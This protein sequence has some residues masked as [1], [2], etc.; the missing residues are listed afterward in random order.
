MNYTYPPEEYR[1]LLDAYMELEKLAFSPSDSRETVLN[2]LAA[3]TAQ[4]CRIADKASAMVRE[5][6]E[7]FLKAPET[8][9]AVDVEA[10]EAL[11]AVLVP[12]DRAVGLDMAIAYLVSK[13]L[14]DHYRNAG[15]DLRYAEALYCCTTQELA[16]ST[17]HMEYRYPGSPYLG[18]CLALA[19]RF[20][21]LPEAAVK[22]AVQALSMAS[23]SQQ[24][25]DYPLYWRVDDVLCAALG[26]APTGEDNWILC[27][28]YLNILT[29]F[30]SDC[31]S[32][33]ET[34]RTVQIA[35]LRPRLKKIIGFIERHLESGNA[36]TVPPVDFKCSIALTRY[37]LGEKSIDETLEALAK[38]SEGVEESE[39]PMAKA[40]GL[41]L[42][43][44][45]YMQY[46][47]LF[48]ALPREEIARR[49]E[50]CI[51]AVMPKLLGITRTMKDTYYH[52][53]MLRFLRGVGFT[54]SFDEFADIILEMTVFA[55]KA[56]YIHTVMVREIS[57]TIFDAMIK[58]TPEAFDGV[59]GRDAEYIRSHAAQMRTLL[60]E[61]C[62]FHDIGKYYLLDIVENSMRRLTDD[63]FHLI[64][65]HPEAFDDLL[66]PG[67]MTA[68]ERLCCIRDCSRTHHLWHDG[69]RGYPRIPQTKNRPFSNILA[70]ADCLDAATD[71]LGR[72]YR[73]SKGLDVLIG[74]FKEGSG[75]HY[76]P[77][78]VA[79]LEV[80]EVRD[81][82]QYLITEGREEIYY[83]VYTSKEVYSNHQNE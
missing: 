31:E 28:T 36:C 40:S 30:V 26:D 23:F 50:A 19:E 22:Q 52:Y 1:K 2:G 47:Y 3:R 80:P 45:H 25:F 79:A 11:L 4:R 74:E 6:I 39:D 44:L 76:G 78:A 29:M 68:D 75:T 42:L 37:H 57:L 63:E 21:E 10:L 56:L 54:R 9:T 27:I 14:L 69:T 59:A 12:P 73:K 58:R 43:G 8:L 67:P 17:L 61:C 15:D 55:D 51:R 53:N 41:S 64:Q 46:L 13:I 32:A 24:G 18:E 16:L 48:S 71:G 7:P 72:P 82:L 66:P 34:G 81:R 65:T 62:M 33:T 70:I 20:G 83:R 5:Y 49:S 35:S 77:E 38:L 60:G